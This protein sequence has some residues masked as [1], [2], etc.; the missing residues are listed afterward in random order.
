MN[1]GSIFVKKFG[2]K[3]NADKLNTPNAYIAVG[4]S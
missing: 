1:V 3:V 4:G 2:K